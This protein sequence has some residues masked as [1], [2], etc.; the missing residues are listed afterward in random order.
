MSLLIRTAKEV[1]SQ[2]SLLLSAAS[3]EPLKLQTLGS[4]TLDPDDVALA[5]QYLQQPEQWYQ[6]KIVVRYEEAFARWNGSRH[7]FAFASGREALSACLGALGLRP[8]EEVVLPG[9]TCVVV[10]NALL[11]AGL[12]PVYADIELET[13]G[14]SAESVF[15]RV[16]SR[17]KAVL[18]H[19]L[20]GLISRDYQKIVEGCHKRGILVI[21]DCA[22]ATGAELHG[23]KVGLL[24][25][26]AFYS[27]EQSKVF[28]TIQG[29]MAVTENAALA[30]ALAQIQSKAPWPDRFHVNGLLHQTI[31]NYYRFKHP[32]RL[33]LG[34]F[35]ELLHG[36]RKVISTTDA[37]ER[38][39]RP[40][41][42]GRR[43]AAPQA[44][45]GI[46]QLA[47]LD[48]YNQRRRDTAARWEKWCLKRGYTPPLVI[49]GSLPVYLRYPFLADPATKADLSWSKKELG[50]EL[51]VWFVS[52]LHPAQNRLV[53]GC[54]KAETAVARCVN[55][56][57]LLF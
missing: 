19:H 45:L 54:P 43:L 41:H 36:G 51:G 6:N 44:A 40:P 47:K 35:A 22:Q 14:P 55:L 16:T 26:V 24:G 52:Q 4:Q 10:P 5:H 15:S 32:Q 12:R 20:Y 7:A 42:Y 13:F 30:S 53:P 1:H 27:S 56:P 34:S 2:A 23:H 9:Y 3:G 46:N 28:N 39:E 25:D 38:G 8:G 49:P 48:D 57:G 50:V 21:E 18:L 17:T 29:G 31:R 33:W 11:F 37:D